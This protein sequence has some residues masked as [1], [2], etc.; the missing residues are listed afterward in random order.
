MI[1]VSVEREVGEGFWVEI[2]EIN[3]EGVKVVGRGL[4]KDADGSRR[5]LFVDRSRSGGECDELL[6]RREGHWLFVLGDLCWCSRV[7]VGYI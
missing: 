2:V 6:V 5:C 3:G 4:G 1:F 7:W